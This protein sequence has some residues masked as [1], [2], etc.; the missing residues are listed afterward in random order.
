MRPVLDPVR[1]RAARVSPTRSSRVKF[2]RIVAN[3]IVAAQVHPKTRAAGAVFVNP[4]LPHS[5]A[6]RIARS[7]RVGSFDPHPPRTS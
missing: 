3:S 5:K 7:I 1:K 6:R 4:R 2:F